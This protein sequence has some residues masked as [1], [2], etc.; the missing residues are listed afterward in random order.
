MIEMFLYFCCMWVIIRVRIT[1]YHNQ[2]VRVN[3]VVPGVLWFVYTHITAIKV[4]FPA[5]LRLR[6][7]VGST[8]LY[9]ANF[10]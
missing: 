1:C 2:Y 8:T 6:K 10:M 9:R 4:R 3:V 5:L 7:C